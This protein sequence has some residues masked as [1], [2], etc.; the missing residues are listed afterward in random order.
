MIGGGNESGVPAKIPSNIFL[1]GR[2][3][4]EALPQFIAHADLC[5]LLYRPAATSSGDPTKLYE[6]LASGHPIV[7]TPHPRAVEMRQWLHLAAT[8][9]EYAEAVVQALQERNP[10]QV[11][12][13]RALASLHTWSR[14]AASL[15]EGLFSGMGQR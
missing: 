8:P 13:R 2:K 9:A 14:R 1:L 3:A 10:A 4:Y 6:Y 5:L 12:A 7:S 15:R 11:Q